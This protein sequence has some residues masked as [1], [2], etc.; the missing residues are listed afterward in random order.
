M[1]KPHQAPQPS[2]TDCGESV[3]DTRSRAAG[4]SVEPAA[5]VQMQGCGLDVGAGPGAARRPSGPAALRS[6]RCG[7]TGSS[8]QTRYCGSSMMPVSMPFSHL[9]H[10][11]S[12]FLEE[13]DARAGL[14]EMRIFM[15]PGADQTLLRALQMGQHARDGVGIAVGP[16]AHEID[17]A[18]DGAPILA[19][20]AMLPER[21]AALMPQPIGD[22]QRLVA[23]AAS[24]RPRASARPAA[25]C[26]ACATYR[27]SITEAHCRLS[28][29]RQPPM[30]WMS[31][32]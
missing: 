29:S 18:G 7:R 10:Q 6:K 22:Q 17:G 9:S 8:I 25:P 12:A 5:G 27:P 24:A 15:R 13:A 30:K 20:R 28:F 26:R 21:V 3:S 14:G 1:P 11:R 23:R 4:F 31:S 16:A 32:A 19:D 2:P